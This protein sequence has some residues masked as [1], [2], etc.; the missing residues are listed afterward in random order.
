MMAARYVRYFIILTILLGS[1]I[2][3]A[4]TC[5]DA[6]G[7]CSQICDETEGEIECS[8][9]LHGTLQADTT[10]CVCDEDYYVDTEDLWCRHCNYNQWSQWSEDCSVT[11]GVEGVRQRTRTVSAGTTEACTDTLR[12]KMCYN[13]SCREGES[14]QY[15]STTISADGTSST[16][17]PTATDT[18]STVVSSSTT[19]TSATLTATAAV[20]SNASACPVCDLH[21][22]CNTTTSACECDIGYY[23]TGTEC[24]ECTGCSSGEY[25]LSPCNTT[26]ATTDSVCAQ[27]STSSCPDGQYRP[28]CTGLGLADSQCIACAACPTS[29]FN[30]GCDADANNGPGVCVLCT[31]CDPS[32]YVTRNCTVS[33][34]GECASCLSVLAE[35]L[36]CDSADTCTKCSANHFIQD[37]G[38]ED[39]RRVVPADSNC[40]L[41]HEV[42]CNGTDDYSCTTC[43]SGYGHA[44]GAAQGKCDQVNAC[45]EEGLENC[46]ICE[47]G[48]CL[49]CKAGYTDTATKCQEKCGGTNYTRVDNCLQHR[50]AMEIRGYGQ[51]SCAMCQKGY[52]RT[53]VQ[54]LYECTACKNC[55]VGEY[56][57]AECSGLTEVDVVNCT[58]CAQQ[59]CS[60]GE[61]IAGCPGDGVVD[62][63]QCLP[64][65][66]GC[67]TLQSLVGVC[68]GSS[69]V[70]TSACVAVD[71]VS[72]LSVPCSE[73]VTNKEEF[74]QRFAAAFEAQNYN[75]LQVV[76]DTCD[77]SRRRQADSGTGLKM[78]G[79][80]DDVANYIADVAV[81][82]PYTIEL[83]VVGVMTSSGEIVYPGSVLPPEPGEST[84]T[85]DGDGDDGGLGQED[86]IALSVSLSVAALIIVV[87]IVVIFRK[88]IKTSR[89]SAQDSS[90]E[91]IEDFRYSLQHLN[92]SASFTHPPV[93][94]TV[95]IKAGASLRDTFHSRNGSVSD[96]SDMLSGSRGTGEDGSKLL[97]FGAHVVALQEAQ[98]NSLPPSSV[99]EVAVSA[100]MDPQG[101]AVIQ[102]IGAGSFSTAVYEGMLYRPTMVRP[103]QPIAITQLY[104]GLASSA[105]KEDEERV[106]RDINDITAVL[107]IAHPC[108]VRVVGLFYGALGACVVSELML[109]SIH[110]VLCNREEYDTPTSVSERAWMSFQ[111]SRGM[112]FLAQNNIVHKHLRAS[113]CLLTHPD[114]T[115]HGHPVVKITN[116]GLTA[117][118][119]D[120]SVSD[121]SPIR[122]YAP[123]L[124]ETENATATKASDMWAFGVTMWE[125]YGEGSQPYPEMRQRMRFREDMSAYLNAGNRLASPHGCPEAAFKAMESCWHEDP[126]ARPSF[127][128]MATTTGQ[129]FS[130][131]CDSEVHVEKFDGEVRL[132]PGPPRNEPIPIEDDGKYENREI[133]YANQKDVQSGSGIDYLK[134]DE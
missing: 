31:E 9:H 92:K 48:A 79:S 7:G 41:S 23:G 61:H 20:A 116:Y 122:W 17:E 108:C 28:S 112:L 77:T 118:I 82:A 131:H 45:E 132:F 40:D 110:Y 129:I 121:G 83:G 5:D 88:R 94:T 11:C 74:D 21:A 63:S 71:A 123:E 84:G 127:Q 43:L 39:C 33:A 100:G 96:K 73:Y 51:P 49:D 89:N 60:E 90:D 81:K 117:P 95:S 101:I 80:N 66:E 42:F 134:E 14:I 32:Q 44:D 15:P 124:C 65:L 26:G 120:Y 114:S 67:Q 93:P 98:Q 64:C 109:G 85:S 3:A 126:S 12:E 133:M 46:Q 27:C 102:L 22:N 19:A 72:Y 24:Q 106:R 76:G 53:V 4:D 105:T 97:Q 2:I 30:S 128:Q 115:S 54:G 87:A 10:T 70:D 52:Y 104:R 18:V 111:V 56:K 103:Y 13:G 35:C 34:D 55:T 86:V 75:T 37:G 6:N 68:N 107:G 78:T 125:I 1:Y 113:N 59:S 58:S 62:N 99:R 130:E 38:C 29:S 91:E 57:D 36:E 8:C 25:I 69:H 47:E 50:C 119:L 16:A